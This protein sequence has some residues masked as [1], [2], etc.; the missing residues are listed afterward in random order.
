MS[1]LDCAPEESRILV[2][3]E[4]A[5]L[6]FESKSG[7]ICDAEKLRAVIREAGFE[8]GEITVDGKKIP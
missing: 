3:V 7:E 5:R 2:D 4:D 1:R 8:V 6:D